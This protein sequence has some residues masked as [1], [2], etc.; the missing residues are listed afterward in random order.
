MIHALLMRGIHK[1]VVSGTTIVGHRARP[2]PADDFG[3][4]F[5]TT[6]WVNGIT[7]GPIAADPSMEPGGVSSDP[8]P[9]FV[10]GEVRRGFDVLLDLLVDRLQSPARPQLMSDNYNARLTTSRIPDPRR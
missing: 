5:A 2:V 4:D 9:R 7:S 10:R 8:P 6:S 1:S 3:Q